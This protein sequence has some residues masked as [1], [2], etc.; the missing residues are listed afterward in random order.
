M[1]QIHL[2]ADILF[3]WNSSQLSGQNCMFY[4]WHL[5]KAALLDIST[6]KH[7]LGVRKYN[8]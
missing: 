4:K 3:L 6:Q 2:H 8:P 1:L 5:C 7:K